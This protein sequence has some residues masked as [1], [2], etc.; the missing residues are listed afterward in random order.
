[1][2][3]P[4][5]VSRPSIVSNT[6]SPSDGSFTT[7][8]AAVVRKSY[9]PQPPQLCREP[10]SPILDL[11]RHWDRLRP[12]SAVATISR[13]GAHNLLAVGRGA[14]HQRPRRVWHTCGETG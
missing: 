8:F 13:S 9:R 2:G 4:P 12:G 3:V 5:L 1:M 11:M 6:G 10:S 7:G 14:S